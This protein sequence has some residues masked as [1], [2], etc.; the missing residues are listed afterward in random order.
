MKEILHRT[1]DVNLTVWDHLSGIF[2]KAFIV[3]AI[4]EQDGPIPEARLTV[5][6]AESF[7]GK[8]YAEASQLCSPN[9]AAQ[10]DAKGDA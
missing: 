9:I 7:G 10:P 5:Y 8:R 4:V 2:G 1:V 6:A 3:G